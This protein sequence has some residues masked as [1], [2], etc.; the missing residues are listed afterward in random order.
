[1]F[2]TLVDGQYANPVMV[3]DEIDKARGE[4]AYDPLGALYSLLE[5]DTAAAFTDEFAEVAIDASQVIWV[6]TANDERAIP[7]P[8]LNRMNVFEVQPR[9]RR[10]AHDRAAPVPASAA[11]RLGPR[12][13]PEPGDACSTAGRPGAARDAPRLDDGLRQCPA[14][15]VPRRAEWTLVDEDAAAEEVEVV[16]T[17]Q[18]VEGGAE[19]ELRELQAR[20]ATLR[21]QSAVGARSNP[22]RPE[23]VARSLWAAA[24]ALGLPGPER[25]VLLRA[26]SDPLT[27]AMQQA[28]R[29]AVAWLT[30]WGVEPAAWKVT[31]VA[32]GRLPAPPSS[33]FDVTR[34]GALDELRAVASGTGSLSRDGT[35]LP[36]VSHGAAGGTPAARAASDQATQAL[37][38][39]LFERMLGDACLAAPVLARVGRLQP[40]V[41]RVALAQPQLFD[42][43]AHPLWRLL[44]RMATQALGYADE[45]DPRLVAYL[46]QLDPWVADLVALR[47]PD[48]AQLAEAVAALE[49]L[50]LAHLRAEQ[51]SLGGAIERLRRAEREAEAGASVR[52][53]MASVLS[54]PAAQE[55]LSPLLRDLF[56][57]PWCDAIGRVAVRDGAGSPLAQRLSAL[58][59]QLL[60]SL[61]PMPTPALR[62]QALRQLPALAAALQEGL[63]LTALPAAQ[64]DAVADELLA[65]HTEMLKGGRAAASASTS[66]E[67]IVRRLREEDD[68]TGPGGLDPRLAPP[69]VIDEGQLD[70]LPAEMVDT[71]AP[72]RSL[73]CWWWRSRRARCSTSRKRTASSSATTTA[74]TCSC[75]CSVSNS[76]HAPA[77]PAR[78]STSCWPSTHRRSPRSAGSRW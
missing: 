14:G 26:A 49:S 60:D 6:A 1:V 61:Q 56:A 57:G 31:S 10:G 50:C 54:S 8:I 11:A 59:Q 63:Q 58:P 67:D 65:R 24:Q 16:R 45:G 22:L 27:P 35:G 23:V 73:R 15:P 20:T 25:R 76:R 3:V 5:H 13:E 70:T 71:A 29:D 42:D 19:W 72:V 9:P 48:P 36:G 34:P 40:V 68:A 18:L 62:A 39:A 17:I 4:H 37:L 75:S 69:T 43:H 2:E 7:E 78:W 21:G 46:A 51:K 32:S 47:Q 28:C 66:A 33:G 77:W 55:R 53:Q 12:F 30:Q 74:P 44:N 38:A 52:A 41:L 64:R